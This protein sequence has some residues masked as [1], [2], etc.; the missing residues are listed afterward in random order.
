MALSH[1]LNV[2]Y[3]NVT[4]DIIELQEDI[5]IRMHI[6]LFINHTVMLLALK[7]SKVCEAL[8]KRLNSLI[9]QIPFHI[10]MNFTKTYYRNHLWSMYSWARHLIFRGAEV[11]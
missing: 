6:V 5:K 11:T 7:Y 2:F 9:T 8:K 10:I 3:L 4:F 1:L